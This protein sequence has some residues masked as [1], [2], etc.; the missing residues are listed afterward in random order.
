MQWGSSHLRYGSTHWSLAF[1][2]S[3]VCVYE[4]HQAT[5]TEVKKLGALTEKESAEVANEWFWYQFYAHIKSSSEGNEEG[6]L[7]S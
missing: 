5:V 3:F 6:I 7:E 4:F 2:I 1:S